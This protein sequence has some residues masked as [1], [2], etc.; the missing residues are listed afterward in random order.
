MLCCVAFT[1]DILRGEEEEGCVRALVCRTVYCIVQY[2][3]EQ[4]RTLQH[5]AVQNSTEHYITATKHCVQRGD[6]KMIYGVIQ[7]MQIRYA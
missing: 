2:S 7:R 4:S 1:L 6:D 3:T 5:S